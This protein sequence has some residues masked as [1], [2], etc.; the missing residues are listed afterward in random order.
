MRYQCR[1]SHV[2]RCCSHSSSI[3]AYGIYL[4]ERGIN[5]P[6][7]RRR[8]HRTP[9]ALGV[10]LMFVG[11]VATSAAAIVIINLFNT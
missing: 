1:L 5:T 4:T 3:T 9:T 2:V 10:T 11:A 6:I 8:D 7:H